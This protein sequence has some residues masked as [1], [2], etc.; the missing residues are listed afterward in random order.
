MHNITVDIQNSIHTAQY[1]A[2]DKQK[3]DGCNREMSGEGGV[4][5]AQE[6]WVEREE[7]PGEK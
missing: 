2:Q 7:A 5:V 3:R 4:D 1:R 6:E